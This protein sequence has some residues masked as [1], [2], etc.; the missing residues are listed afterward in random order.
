MDRFSYYF[1]QPVSSSEFNGGFAAAETAIWNL[2]RDQNIYGVIQGFVAFA[3]GG[4]NLGVG[5]GFGLDKQGRR[6]MSTGTITTSALVDTLGV[7]TVPSAGHRRWVSFYARWGRNLSDPR[8]DGLGTAIKFNQAEALNPDDVQADV[9]KLLVV[10]GVEAL[11]SSALPARPALD[12]S[13]ILVADVLLTDGDSSIFTTAIDT[14]R[15]ERIAESSLWQMPSAG[16]FSGSA[17]RYVLV[18]SYPVN[19]DTGL[20]SRMYASTQGLCITTN[21]SWDAVALLWTPDVASGGASRVTFRT[22]GILFNRRNN[23]SAPWG[24]GVWDGEVRL[25]ASALNDTLVIDAGT[26][27]V[28][29]G[30]Q[31]VLWGVQD[32]LT[33]TG[34]GLTKGSFAT[35]P[36]TF[37]G[38]PSSITQS[39]LG[40][41]AGSGTFTTNVAAFQYPNG[42]FVQ[43]TGTVIGVIRCFRTIVA[44][45]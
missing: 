1:K 36:K 19:S 13:A 20:A 23:V 28:S 16:G 17:D 18:A 4:F 8:T 38:T 3:G 41:D 22:D 32:E 34:G 30:N 15:A 26:D 7:S 31:T 37:T 43:L 33:S 40:S 45:L 6:L 2:M 35:F 24:D 42:V 9:G 21:C 27:T 39:T 14:A 11:T 25:L 29:G 5:E 44:S 10:R 12:A